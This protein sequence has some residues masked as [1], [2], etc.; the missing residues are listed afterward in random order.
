MDVAGFATVSA[1]VLI[2]M[3]LGPHVA[4]LVFGKFAV[5]L[6]WQLAQ[7]RAARLFEG[8]PQGHISASLVVPVLTNKDV[9][10]HNIFSHMTFSERLAGDPQP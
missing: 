1:H 8:T 4:L 3:A 5:G 10:S 6:D 2:K 9:A 7:S